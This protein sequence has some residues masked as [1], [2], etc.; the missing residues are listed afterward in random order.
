MQ[1]KDKIIKASWNHFEGAKD[2]LVSNI[3]AASRDGRIKIE[4]SVLPQLLSLLNASLEE[5]YHK[6]FNAFDKE[7]SRSLQDSPKKI[8]TSSSKKN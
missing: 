1:N 6:G 5:G 3:I 2:V 8:T 7:L 4:N